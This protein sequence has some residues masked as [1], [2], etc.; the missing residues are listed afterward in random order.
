MGISAREF[1]GDESARQAGPKNLSPQEFSGGGE[2]KVHRS[3]N[4]QEQLTNLKSSNQNIVNRTNLGVVAR[5]GL[6][7]GERIR[8]R[9]KE[10]GAILKGISGAELRGE[11]NFLESMLQV[12]GKVGAGAV[13]DIMGEG[14]V[15][16]VKT[17]GGVIGN[18]TPDIIKKPMLDAVTAGAHLFLNT[19][20][21]QQ[22]L[23]AAKRG[24]EA[25]AGF[26]KENPRAARNIEAVVDIGL[27]AAPVKAKPKSGPTLPGQAGAK[28]SAAADKQVFAKKT[29]FVD[30]LVRPKQTATVREAQVGRTTEEGILKTKVTKLSELEQR[31]AAEVLKLPEI[32]TKKTLQGNHNVISKAISKEAEALSTSLSKTDVPFPRKELNA[33]FSRALDRLK[34]NPLLVG[35]AEKTA[36][37]IMA[38]MIQIV[39]ARKSTASNLLEARK[40][41]DRWIKS[42]KG[43]NIFDP[44]KETALS[45]A[46]REIRQTTNN[47][48]DK[49]AL[50]AGVKESL[51]KQSNLFTALDS[52]APKA[53]DEARNAVLRAWKNLL[54][55]LPLRGEFNQTMAALFGV[56]GLGASALF[57][58]VFT[59]LVLGGIGVYG[60]GKLLMSPSTKRGLAMLLNQTDKAIRA[61]KDANLI[62]TLRADRAAVLELL[63]HGETVIQNTE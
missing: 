17:A 43:P 3:Q 39:E 50:G 53:A 63:Q 30:S 23:R 49:K 33:E 57:A 14:L 20:V 34:T 60:T 41:L 54:N 10:R 61:T 48:I 35:D 42:Q 38:K 4:E 7:T 19:R 51:R 32:S 25:Y 6:E 52:L 36:V 2:I 5:E 26:K 56:G 62:R 37:K 24:L 18:L 15:G 55:V 29:D 44:A 45:I 21:G 28:L 13:L 16:A 58:P 22:G 46:I 40:D 11:Q 59:K 1:F 27:L 12:S 31:S 8:T 47:F 9:L